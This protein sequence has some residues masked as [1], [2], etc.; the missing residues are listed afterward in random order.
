MRGA[1][2][3]K[4]EGV[5]LDWD[6]TWLNWIR[7]VSVNEATF[8]YAQS[9]NGRVQIGDADFALDEVMPQYDLVA[10]RLQQLRVEEVRLIKN[11]ERTNE[12]LGTHKGK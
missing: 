7:P 5:T 10:L 9:P 8:A 2:L 11:G 3:L 6:E 12:Y 4:P 1:K